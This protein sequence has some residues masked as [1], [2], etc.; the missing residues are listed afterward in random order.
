MTHPLGLTSLPVALSSSG[1]ELGF[2]STAG[3]PAK[4]SVVMMRMSI[5][6]MS[7]FVLM[8]SALAELT[9]KVLVKILCIENSNSIN[10]KRM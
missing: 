7:I 1:N 4:L 3:K 5:E 9:E 10:I 6:A 2:E 8:C